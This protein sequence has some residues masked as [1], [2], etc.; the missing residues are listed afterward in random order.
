MADKMKAQVFY[1]PL[2]MR[3][4]ER[5]IPK[6]ADDQVLARVKAC[7]ICGSD[8][9]YYWGESPLETPDGKGPLILGHEFTGQVTEVGA[10]PAKLGL[11][12]PGDRV[13]FDPVQYCNACEIC[14]RGQVNLCE[15]KIV[16][17]VAND[18][19]FAEYM[20]ADARF[21]HQLPSEIGD[22]QAAPL[23]CAGIIGY[24]SL[25]LADLQPGE[26]L[27]LV[28]FGASAHIVIQL[29]RY[30]DCEVFV[31]TRSEEHRNHARDLGAVWVGGADDEAPKPLDRAIIFAPAGYL[32]PMILR[33]LRPA[34][35]LAI[36][37][38]HMSNIPEMEYKET[39]NKS[40]A[41]FKA[42]D[43]AESF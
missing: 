12:E 4:E 30:W 25:R 34:G 8:I 32:V 9:A 3:L 31:F 42:I 2:D 38:I 24:R 19:G 23:L 11:F 5:D 7:S 18:G 15:N 37:A 13:V 22:D 43:L 29:A 36:N 21:L 16:L 27:G 10:I 33:K 20:V 14:K 40:K 17:G 39:L 1:E 41:M 35:T 6:P 28:G 26:R